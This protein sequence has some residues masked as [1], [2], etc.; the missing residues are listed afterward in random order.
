MVSKELLKSV[1]FFDD[2]PDEILERLA[3]IADLREYREGEYLNRRRRSADNLYVILQGT[4][5]LEVEDIKGEIVHLETLVDG[6]ALGFSSLVDHEPRRYLSDARVVTPTRALRFPS[7]NIL[8]LCYQ[9]P[10]FG[11]LMMKQIALIARERLLFRTQ[12]IDKISD[13]KPT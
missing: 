9:D 10:E 13:A 2:F 6:A 7:D 12:P 5:S 1:E 11:F 8:S 3:G 4:V